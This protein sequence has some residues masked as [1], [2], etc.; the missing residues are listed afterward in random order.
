MYPLCAF[1]H[2]DPVCTL[3]RYVTSRQVPTQLEPGSDEVSIP[4]SI[5]QRNEKFDKSAH[6]WQWESNLRPFHPE[7]YPFS[8][9]LLCVKCLHHLFR[10]HSPD[11]CRPY[12]FEM[13]ESCVQYLSRTKFN[14]KCIAVFV[15]THT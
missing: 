3:A 6:A 4:Q 8:K 11:T 1:S 10:S 9:R 2:K 12:L 5:H 7:F 14:E 13:H 15:K